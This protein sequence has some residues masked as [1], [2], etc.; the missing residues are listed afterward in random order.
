MLLCKGKTLLYHL[1]FLFCKQCNT[2]ERH[3]SSSG[4]ALAA[5]CGLVSHIKNLSH[6]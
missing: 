4:G 3:L 1:V 6:T 5:V 2:I